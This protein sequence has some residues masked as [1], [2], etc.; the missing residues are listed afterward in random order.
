MIRDARFEENETGY[1]LFK[2][3]VK[4]GNLDIVLLFRELLDNSKFLKLLLVTAT[5]YNHTNIIEWW[6]TDAHQLPQI[7]AV[8]AKIACSTACQ[9]GHENALKLW[10]SHYPDAFEDTKNQKDYIVRAAKS[11]STAVVSFLIER[12][13]EEVLSHPA[14]IQ[15]T[16]EAGCLPITKLLFPLL[17][18]PK[19]FLYSIHMAPTRENS[20]VLLSWYLW[21]AVARHLWLGIRDET[22]P[23]SELPSEFC[24]I[25]SYKLRDAF[26][27][28]LVAE[29]PVD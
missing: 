9:C 8:L 19:K 24:M 23:L 1:F 13:N 18:K 29:I 20:L 6:F 12:L 11:G 10:H 26:E 2:S 15:A 3:A 27:D 4:G 5:K 7:D 21:P 22:S 17:K 28:F 14:A 16:I 25:L